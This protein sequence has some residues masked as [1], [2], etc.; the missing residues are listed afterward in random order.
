VPDATGHLHCGAMCVMA[1][2]TCTT[3]AD[4]CTG[5]QCVVPPG[6]LQGTCTIPTNPNPTPDGGT[7]PDLL[8]APACALYGQACATTTPC[9]ANEGMCLRPYANGST[10]CTAGDTDC[11]CYNPLM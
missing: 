8:G 1:N 2:G 7:P 10:A 6:T 9:C 3:T 11:T 4:C 5:L